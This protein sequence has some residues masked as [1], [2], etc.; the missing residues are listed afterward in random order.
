MHIDCEIKGIN[1]SDVERLTKVIS[2][3]TKCPGVV[4]RDGPKAEFT[5][6]I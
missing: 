3:K 5:Q 4:L 2:K 1:I 6:D